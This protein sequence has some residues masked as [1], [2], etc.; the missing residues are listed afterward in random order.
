MSDITVI[1]NNT[2]GPGSVGDLIT[3]AEFVNRTLVL[4]TSSPMGEEGMFIVARMDNPEVLDLNSIRS[5]RIK[6][7]TRAGWGCQ[8]DVV[9]DGML[10]SFAFVN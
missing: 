8:L 10:R 6:C 5:S 7:I 1:Q 9:Q 3:S 2:I 4:L